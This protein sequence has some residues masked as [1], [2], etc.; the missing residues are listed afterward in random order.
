MDKKIDNILLK[1]L[2]I[3]PQGELD[4]KYTES[5]SLYRECSDLIEK[6]YLALGK[7]KKYNITTQSST[8]GKID[9]KTTAATSQI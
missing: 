5:I 2:S 8:Y 1:A 3:D 6:T 4:K 7:K 9:T